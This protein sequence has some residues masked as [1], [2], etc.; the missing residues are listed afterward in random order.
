MDITGIKISQNNRFEWG[1]AIFA[2]MVLVII[3]T[4]LCVFSGRKKQKKPFKVTLH[5]SQFL[6]STLFVEK[7][8][9]RLS[10][11]TDTIV[12]MDHEQSDCYTQF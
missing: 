10:Q 7:A 3:I 8:L 1:C 5:K 11:S 4:I 9:T 6:Q 2:G 12:T